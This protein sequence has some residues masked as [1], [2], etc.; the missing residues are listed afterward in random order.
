MKKLHRRA[1]DKRIAS[2]CCENWANLKNGLSSIKIDQDETDNDQTFVEN[3][4]N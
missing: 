4:E 1:F 2:F 3:C